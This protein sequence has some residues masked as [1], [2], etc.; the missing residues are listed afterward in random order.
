MLQAAVVAQLRVLGSAHP[1]TRAT[2]KS[3]ESV[4]SAMRAKPT[5]AHTAGYLFITRRP[6]CNDLGQLL[7]LR[8]LYLTECRNLAPSRRRV[9][10]GP[11]ASE[12]GGDG[13]SSDLRRPGRDRRAA[14]AALCH[15]ATSVRQV[16]KELSLR[17]IEFSI[18]DG[19]VQSL[20]DRAS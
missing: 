10:E 11:A 2:V 15:S 9:A 5:V 3:L 16:L 8:A 17:I 14:P 4:R 6:S 1:D 7:G 18:S 19:L 20:P 13:G 12:M